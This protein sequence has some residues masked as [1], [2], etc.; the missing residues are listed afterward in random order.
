MRKKI[1]I[2]IVLTCSVLMSA[3]NQKNDAI[4]LMQYPKNGLCAI[5][6][7][8]NQSTFSVGDNI[9]V[10]GWAVMQ[11]QKNAADDLIVYLKN[12][13][14]NKLH[15][16]NAHIGHLRTDV[17]IALNSPA[18]EHSGFN[19]ILEHGSLAPGTYE[20]VLLQLSKTNDAVTC[21]GE[22]HTINIL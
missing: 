20:I 6:I 1:L 4:E 12:T 2:F 14:T 15:S 19:I 5:D 8:P 13:K 18:A 22:A 9:H 10:G 11:P 17:A 16:A 21:D 7:P 3:C